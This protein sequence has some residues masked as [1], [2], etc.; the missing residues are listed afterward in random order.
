M[1]RSK[2]VY[3]LDYFLPGLTIYTTFLEYLA[4]ISL[5]ASGVRSEEM[6]GQPFR[7]PRL[8]P[9]T[10]IIDIALHNTLVGARCVSPTFAPPKACS[11]SNLC[12][13]LR[14]TPRSFLLPACVYS[15]S[16]TVVVEP[17]LG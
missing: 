14:A 3:I 17:P 8:L 12:S 16:A 1:T 15:G 11:R 6:R 10:P 4:I 5:Y 13:F 2:I 7:P 9:N